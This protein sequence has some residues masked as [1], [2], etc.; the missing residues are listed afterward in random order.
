MPCCM[1]CSPQDRFQLPKANILTTE[2][3]ETHQDS[4]ALHLVVCFY[5]VL[6]LLPIACNL[7]GLPSGVLS[8]LQSNFQQVNSKQVTH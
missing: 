4:A 2:S 3:G 1:L 5:V 7:W 8:K 6:C